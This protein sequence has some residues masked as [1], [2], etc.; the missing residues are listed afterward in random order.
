LDIFLLLAF[1]V[2]DDPVESVEALAPELV[3]PGD[4][5]GFFL[6]PARPEL[7]GAD[8]PD[9]LRDHEPG[10]LQHAD[11]LLHAG[12]GHV[13]A[14]GEV[15]DRGVG[16]AELLEDAPAGDVREG[17]EG[18]IEGGLTLNHIVHCMSGRSGL[19]A[20]FR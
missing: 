1:E 2:F 15:A 4:P 12:Q 18:G 13:E 8:A 7:A 14:A 5:G 19:Q 6:E 16:A 9:F 10:L 17:G 20:F 11:V 3:V